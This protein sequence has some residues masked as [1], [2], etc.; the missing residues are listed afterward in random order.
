[1]GAALEAEACLIA[2]LDSRRPERFSLLATDHSRSLEVSL[3]HSPAI[4]SSNQPPAVSPTS[5][6]YN[7]W[8]AEYASSL[9]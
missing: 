6:P 9:L 8:E 4:S 7:A 2:L 3:L 1:L 5:K